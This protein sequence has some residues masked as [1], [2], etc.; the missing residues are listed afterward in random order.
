MLSSYI[1][2]PLSLL[3]IIG[4]AGPQ[5]Y[6]KRILGAIGLALLAQIAI[7]IFAV[8]AASDPAARLMGLS[9]SADAVSRVVLAAIGVAA[10][11][12]LVALW[13]WTDCKTD[14]Y[15]LVSLFLLSVTAMNATVLTTDLFTLYVFVEIVAIVSFVMIAFT[16]GSDGLEGAFKYLVMSAVAS[17]MMLASLAILFMNTGTLAFGPVADY[18][19]VFA[20]SASVK[21]AVVLFVSGALIKSGLVPFHGWLPDA[22]EG[23]PAPVSV[24]LAG[25]IT[26]ASG[27]YVLTRVVLSVFGLTHAG[28]IL[29]AVGLV[30]IVVGALGAI[31]QT[32][33][34]R[35]L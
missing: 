16:G 34:K 31:A 25:V 21:A 15:R 8:E 10:I 19:S 6:S 13:Y 30:S 20:H 4:I 33:L 14:G 11:S 3:V 5:S 2:L 7:A 9:L 29:A 1:L 12:A 35:M 28:P 17:V 23:A 18:A 32:N 27:V 22:Y 24:L 26:K